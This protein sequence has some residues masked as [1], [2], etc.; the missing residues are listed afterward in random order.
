MFT[1]STPETISIM[2]AFAARNNERLAGRGSFN[3]EREV[4]NRK[5][6]QS[7]FQNSN[8]AL[9][10][11]ELAAPKSTLGIVGV[12]SEAFLYNY[13]VALPN[14]TY[15]AVSFYPSQGGNFQYQIWFN[16]TLTSNVTG[17][18]KS[19]TYG[20]SIHSLMRGMDEAII[21]RLATPLNPTPVNIDVSIKDWPRI[22]SRGFSNRVV[23]RFGNTFYFSACIFVF[24]SGVNQIIHGIHG[25]QGT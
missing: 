24:M 13:L 14:V 18:G 6:R 1:P 3:V 11:L 22:P 21:A 5:P 15:F 16:Y 25:P 8:P 2:T 12:P 17:E 4:L 7:R 19:D 20:M 9:H 23:S 10:C